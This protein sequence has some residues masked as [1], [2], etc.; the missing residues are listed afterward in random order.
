ML[1]FTIDFIGHQD[2]NEDPHPGTIAYHLENLEM[3]MMAGKVLC[4]PAPPHP[5]A[6]KKS[7]VSLFA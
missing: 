3:V 1:N 5:L 2:H 4:S 6:R 7:S